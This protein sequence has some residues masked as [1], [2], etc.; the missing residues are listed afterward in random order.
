LRNIPEEWHKQVYYLI[1]NVIFTRLTAEYAIYGMSR[2]HVPELIAMHT[3]KDSSVQ[4]FAT[5]VCRVPYDR[6]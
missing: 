6:C 2:P 1:V 4:S 5:I 3:L